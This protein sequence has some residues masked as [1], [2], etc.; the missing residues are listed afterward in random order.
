[1]HIYIYIIR[2]NPEQSTKLYNMIGSRITFILIREKMN[3][4]DYRNSGPEGTH[5]RERIETAD[6]NFHHSLKDYTMSP[7][8]P[9][10]LREKPHLD[11]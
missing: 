5:M 9:I 6:N 3:D 7:P 10:S 1:M 2:C 4:K 8:V 11:A